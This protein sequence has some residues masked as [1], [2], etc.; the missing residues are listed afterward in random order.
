MHSATH[1][2]LE[3]ANSRGDCAGAAH[4]ARR[5]VAS[6]QKSV[7]ERPDFDAPIA[8]ELA[9]HRGVMSTEQIAPALVAHLLGARG[10]AD[11][12]RE[13]DG[14]EHPVALTNGNRSGEELFDKV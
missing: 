5:A 11:D 3:R 8:R 7:A 13:Q 9:P 1:F 6:P 10:R 14:R 12:V 4:G 2:N